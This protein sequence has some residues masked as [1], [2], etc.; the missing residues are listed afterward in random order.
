MSY[1]INSVR[2]PGLYGVGGLGWLMPEMSGYGLTDSDRIV[3]SAKL[4]GDAKAIQSALKDQGFY[5][6]AVDGVL[7]KGS[8]SAIAA[9]S[10]AKGL[11]TISWPNPTFCAALKADQEKLLVAEFERRNPPAPP[12]AQGGD[13]QPV[14]PVY[15]SQGQ[16]PSQQAPVA[17]AAEDNTMLYIAGAVGLVGV[18][19]AVYLA[20]R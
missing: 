3:P 20:S 2:V 11:G 19:L 10:K 5:S 15:S 17:P 8:V 16:Q 9:Y 14:S 13:G 18:G 1:H 12:P 7:G 4:C 6:G